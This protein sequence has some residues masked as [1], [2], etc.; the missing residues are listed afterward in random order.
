[1]ITKRGYQPAY[2]NEF[3]Y[4]LL[5]GFYLKEG[6]TLDDALARAAEAYCF[7][8]YGL[9]Q[10][11]Y[12]AAHNGWFMY[13]SPILSNAPRGRWDDLTSL[14]EKSLRSVW[15]RASS[16]NGSDAD[17]MTKNLFFA[18]EEKFA[19][20]ISCFSFFLEDSIE[21]QKRALDELASL[22]VSGGGVGIHNGIRATSKKAP[23]P[24]PFAKVLDS[25]I[26]YFQQSS[27]RRGACALYM[28][29]SHP[30][31]IEHIRFR[32]PSGGDHTRKSEN[33]SQFNNAVNVTDEFIDAVLNDEEWDLVDPHTKE[34]RETV[35]ARTL[36]EE[37][38]EV[39]ALTGE[40]Y[41]FKVDTANRFLPDTQKELGL[42]INGSNLCLS[43]ETR[44]MTKAYGYVRIDSIVGKEVEV[45]NGF[46]WSTVTPFET[47]KN[48]S[49]VTV[50][51]SGGH[52]IECT[53]EHHFHIMDGK[54]VVVVEA[55][56]LNEGD[57][58]IKHDLPVIEGDVSN[59]IFWYWNGF[60]SGDGCAFKPNYDRFYFYGDKKNLT[61]SFEQENTWTNKFDQPGQ[62][63]IYYDIR[64]S[65]FKKYDV[66][67][68]E[69]DIETRLA[70]LAGL[71]DA[72]GT[73]ARVV[74]GGVLSETI[75]IGS[76][77]REFL[78]EVQLMLQTLGVH[79]KVTNSHDGG[80]RMAPD[81]RGGYAEY[82]TQPMY[83]LLISS[84]GLYQL[85]SL[86]FETRRLAFEA[87]EPNRDARRFITV[88][89][90]VDEGRISD[91]FCL[92]EPK[93][94]TVLVNG[95]V[96]GQCSEITLPTSEERT[97]VCCLS[98]LN[99]EKYDEWKDTT[100]V[101]DLTRFLDNVI[102]FFIEQA[103][104]GL[105]RAVYSAVKERAIGIGAMG[106]HYYLQSKG[107]NFES[108]GF[109]S[110]VQHSHIIFSD[111]KEK[112]DAESRRLAVERGEPDDMIGS[113][114][115]NSNLLAIAPTSNNS[116]ILG[117]SPAIEPSSGN[118]Y[119]QQTRAGTFMV[120]NP[121]LNRVLSDYAMGEGYRAS[122]LETW[123]EET[124]QDIV[125]SDGSVQHLDFLTDEQKALFKTAYEIDQHWIIEQAD[126]RGRYICQAQSLN[127]FFPAGCDRSYFN[128]V[129]VKALR[130][131]YIKS[132]YY[133]RMK[134]GVQ[135]NIVKDLERK[136]LVDW[137]SSDDAAACVA[138]EG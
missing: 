52:T 111:I 114:R 50:R 103:G 47:G 131:E 138:C 84:I 58:L 19:M 61:T 102:Q 22:S 77:H 24:I 97:F 122:M 96:T 98:S 62:D 113:G 54:D 132:L 56:N 26:G 8:D 110:S 90:V 13:A 120:K 133:A 79:S 94:H 33:R 5:D 117:T 20:P 15:E 6:E 116:V 2:L 88:E 7:G 43:P 87:N 67:G 27:N 105:E 45:W 65:S 89:E 72:D 29:I 135:R 76:I 118:A 112:A 12:E 17:S 41:I 23:G 55:Q 69:F 31:I 1:M 40:P 51:L 34:I 137:N 109:N 3:S 82:N 123:L 48:R 115:R 42:K 81:G 36:W 71:A 107:I 68:V 46:E 73:I 9:A 125:T 121:Y 11:I 32:T 104:P 25:A 21:G 75:Q 59:P 86:G 49:L 10:R 136:A 128:S 39:R 95:V 126:A 63:R 57:R 93:R 16:G 130:A 18:E 74:S 37:I 4:A 66:P 129:H 119:M 44:V 91:T 99:L 60:F 83:R 124:W 28:D 134:S 80:L 92:T 78:I 100:L 53:P 35:S 64:N 14:S 101:A 108:G 30:D 85:A 70:F 38:L 106:W 127:L